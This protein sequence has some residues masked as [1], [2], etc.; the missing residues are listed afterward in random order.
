[1]L[2][3]ILNIIDTYS[4]FIGL[5]AICASLISIVIVKLK[6]KTAKISVSKELSEIKV[7]RNELE[8]QLNIVKQLTKTATLKPE[9]TLNYE[10]TTMKCP[11]H[12]NVKVIVLPDSTVLCPHGHRLWPPEEKFEKVSSLNIDIKENILEAKYHDLQSQIDEIK[13]K[14]QELEEQSIAGTVIAKEKRSRRKTAE[15]LEEEFEEE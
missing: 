3:E 8:K 15:E 1:M 14:L 2:K 6:T 5:A 12:G 4:G 7:L 10:D 11:K 13:E 9:P